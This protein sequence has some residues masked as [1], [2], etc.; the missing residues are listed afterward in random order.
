[1]RHQSPSRRK[2]DP[3]SVTKKCSSEPGGRGLR[4]CSQRAAVAPGQV[5]GVVVP[6]S[7]VDRLV[8]KVGFFGHSVALLH[9]KPHVPPPKNDRSTAIR[10]GTRPLLRLFSTNKKHKKARS[11]ASYD[12]RHWEPQKAAKVGWSNATQRLVTRVDAPCEQGGDAFGAER[13]W[14]SVV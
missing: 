9:Q 12:G 8:R 2:I 6:C 11:A 4:A 1:M 3:F 7:R 5:P 13:C 10:G 14:L